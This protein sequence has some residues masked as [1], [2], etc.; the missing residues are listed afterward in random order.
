MA[1]PP[2]IV[3]LPGAT[4]PNPVALFDTSEGEFQAEIYMD[5]VPITASN[6]IALCRTGF[7][8]GLHFHR[9]IDGFMCQFG[10]PFSK[11]PESSK[12]GQGSA[13][14]KSFTNLRNG[15]LMC[16]GPGG[17]IRDEHVSRDSN[18]PGS[19]SMANVGQPDTGSS[20]IFLNVGH[21]ASLDWF[22][23][24][25]SRH[26]VFGMVRAGMDVLLKISKCETENEKPVRPIKVHKIQVFGAPEAKEAKRAPPPKPSSSSSSSSSSRRRKRKAKSRKKK[27]SSSSSTSSRVKR[28]RAKKAQRKK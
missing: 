17:T 8:D 27:S 9:V 12:C 24:G 20:Q 6:F 10:C 23:P 14:E 22:S 15:A 28:I 13:P 4:Q 16:R 21:N 1:A 18:V 7:Y 2:F 26:P 19:L 5:R 11:D 25:D 3:P